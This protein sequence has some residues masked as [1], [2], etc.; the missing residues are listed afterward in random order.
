MFVENNVI[1]LTKEVKFCPL[2]RWILSDLGEKILQVIK[3]YR[4]TGD[5][6]TLTPGI[7]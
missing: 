7:S 6:V 4:P 2:L 3:K 1:I 5:L